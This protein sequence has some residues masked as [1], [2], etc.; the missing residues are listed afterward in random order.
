MATRRWEAPV[1]FSAIALVAIVVFLYVVR[2]ILPSFVAAR[3]VLSPLVYKSQGLAADLP[4]IIGRGRRYRR[5]YCGGA[6][7]R[8]AVG[9]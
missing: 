8:R 4:G 5:G 2:G 9:D 3:V 1:R 6:V 7:A